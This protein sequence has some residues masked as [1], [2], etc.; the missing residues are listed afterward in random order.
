MRTSL[1]RRIKQSAAPKQIADARMLSFQAPT[2]GWISNENLAASK[3]AGASV[4]DNFFP[5]STG[6]RPRLGS[7]LYAYV[8]TGT[9]IG[10][11]IPYVFGDTTKLFAANTNAIYNISTGNGTDNDQYTKVL[12]H[13]DGADTSTTITDTNFGGSSHT[14]T[15]NGNA[16]LDTGVTKFGTATLLLDGSGDYVT[17]PDHADFNLADSD[18]TIDCWFNCTATTGT[19]KAIA[20]QMDAAST[21]TSI[22]FFLRRQSTNAIRAQVNVGSTAYNV[23]STTLFTDVVSPGWH[24]IAFVRTGSTLKLFIDGVQEGGDT[25]I[26]GSVNDSSNDFRVGMLGETTGQDWQGSIDE[27]RLSVGIARWTAAFTP[28]TSPYEII[29]DVAS[30]ANGDWQHVQFTTTGGT[31]LRLV[32]GADTPLVYDGSTWSTSPAITGVTASTL[33]HVWA[34]KNRLMFIEDGTFNAW[35]LPVDSIGGAAVK[36]PLGGEFTLGGSLMFGATWSLDTGAG[37]D[38]KCVF[39][40]TEGEVV[41]YG[42]TD[43]SSANTW[44]KQGNYRIGRPLGPRAIVKGGGDLAIA[45]D[46]GLIPLSKAIK[47]DKAAIGAQAVSYQIEEDW[48]AEVAQRVGVYDWHVEMW[49]TKQMAIVA[50]PSYSS[51]ALRC[52]VANL[53]TGAWARFTGWDTH[54][55]GLYRD[56]L[57]FGTSTG[58]II[59]AEVGGLDQGAA[60]TCTYVGLFSDAGAGAQP[61]LPTLMR[62]VYLS[63][64]RVGD[65]VSVCFDYTVTLPTAPDAAA[66]TGGANTWNNGLWNQATW[67]GSE[68]N[69]TFQDWRSVG[70]IGHAVAPIWMVTIGQESAPD[71]QLVRMDMQYTLGMTPG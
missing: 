40:S 10:A 6:I 19:F 27:F 42:G 49:P 1:K 61:K 11:I 22:S 47:I 3:P 44:A 15:A 71:V 51:L 29:P 17:T 5:L 64:N 4:L 23:T 46:I 70:G 12:L 60:Y 50:M 69:Q 43:P 16:Q 28:P 68:T 14:W 13:F 58:T 32:N 26:T 25:A 48:K 7:D 21:S 36:F 2:R 31:F 8:G 57:F 63:P 55:L 20:G 35:Y 67:S 38:E 66:I 52:F 30:L 33:S 39:V 59:E 34:F 24:H 53:R 9:R 62:P 45:T 41:I 56:R 18:F 65:K 37:L 54:C